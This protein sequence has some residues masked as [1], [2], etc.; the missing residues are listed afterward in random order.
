MLLMLGLAPLFLGLWVKEEGADADDDVACSLF[1]GA[2]MQLMLGL[3]PLFLGLWVKQEGADADDA[4]ACS[5][6]F[7]ALG[8]TERP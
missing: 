2:L 3:A 8:E 7:G 5:P 1:F 4:V 6:L